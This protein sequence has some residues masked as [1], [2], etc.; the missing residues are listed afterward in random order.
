MSSIT[1]YIL[2]KTDK[3]KPEPE[4]HNAGFSMFNTGGVEVEVAELLYSLVK[5]WKPSLVVETGTHLGISALYMGLALEENNQGS[6][7]TYEIAA[8]FLQQAQALW[9][10]LGVQNRVHGR[11]K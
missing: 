9:Q 10:D 7:I 1:D 5:V 8:P 2:T 3:I 6:L 4:F 11:L